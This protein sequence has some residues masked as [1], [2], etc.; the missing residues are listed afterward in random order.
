MTANRKSRRATASRSRKTNGKATPD[1]EAISEVP[2]LSRTQK[3]LVRQRFEEVRQL[4]VQLADMVL[5][6]REMESLISAKEAQFRA[7]CDNA[8]R[9]AGVDL[10]DPKGGQYTIDM[11]DDLKVVRR[12]TQPFQL[13]RGEEKQ[14]TA[15]D[16]A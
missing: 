8:L 4:K 14:P 12:R 11:A 9:G 1:D 3:E 2:Q 7:T 10:D 13:Q 6:Q 5:R 16:T 15:A